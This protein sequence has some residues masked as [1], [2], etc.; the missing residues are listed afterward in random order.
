MAN[1]L[2][3]ISSKITQPKSQGASQAMLYGTG[4]TEDDMNKAQVGIASVWYDGN[5]CNMHLMAAAT[6]VKEGVIA[7]GMVGMR[8]NTIGVSDGISM[9]TS[10][11]SFSL[12]S[13]DLIA[14]SIETMM[15]AQWYDANISL[16]GCDKNMP[17]CIM[18]MGRLNRPALMIYGGT[19]KPGHDQ[20]N[21][22]LDIVSAFQS[23]GQCLAGTLSEAERQ[24][25][26]KHACPGAGACGG[27]YTANT[28]ASA[29]EALGMSLPYSSS[30]PAEYPAKLEECFQ[31]GKAIRNL[32]EKDIKPR[33]IM[34]RVAFENAMVIVM[35]L[36]GSTNAVLHL[37]AMAKSVE[38][39]LTLDD[40]QKVSDRI[41]FLA[42][43]K[44]SGEYVMEDIH[45]IGG[46]PAVMKYLLEKGLLNGD[47]LTV[48]GKTVAENLAD[49]P[50]LSEGQEIIRPLE[51]PIKAT[52]HIQILRGNLAPGGAVAKI[53]GKEGLSFTGPAKVYDCE[54]D[55][56][57][58]LERKEIIKGDVVVIRY[59]GPKGGPGMPEMLTPTSAIVGAGLGKEVALLTD[60]RFS[61][62]SH[63]F[64]VGH[65]VPEAQEG[66]TI[67]LLKNG[68]IISID[69]Q[70]KSLSVELS[71]DE[72]AQRIGQWVMPYYKATRGTLYK[73]IKNVKN[74]SDGCVTD[75]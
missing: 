30:T 60:G 9:G 49:L 57:S 3:K 14:D 63:G 70:N 28:M 5:T 7:A 71:D 41:P 11:M 15:A 74:A 46:I 2:N 52:G 68:D 50:G 66:G 55:M 37:I 4:L 34:T 26:V 29:I 65:I 10:G 27:M 24:D 54:E 33:D 44:P 12:Q 48:T 42:D 69:A 16:P 59:E 73:Y 35:A 61:G 39:E 53:T 13:R 72:L 51:N 40:F 21:N 75:E 64:I 17:G 47:C 19:I 56:L 36:G 32:L 31:A 43:L 45:K 67:A 38:V 6:K 25:V 8:F 20:N 18:A 1:P 58:A 62:G 22:P 23:Y